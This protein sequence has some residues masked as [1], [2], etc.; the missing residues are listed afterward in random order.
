MDISTKYLGLELKNP[1]IVGS[2]GL[3][4][5]V[6]KIQKCEEAEAGAVV[7]K[8]LF[9]EQIR[10]MDSGVKGSV[11]MHPEV[12]DYIRSEIDMAYGPREYLKTIEQAKKSVSIPIIASINCYSS[13]WW[14]DYAQQ[15]ELAGADA[16]E[17]NIYT[18]PFDMTKSSTELEAIYLEILQRV[19]EQIKIPVSLK[20]SPYFTS[21]GHLAAKLAA[22]GANGLVLFN[23]FIQPE[24]N[25]DSIKI[26]LKGAFNDPVGFSYAS[27][28]I[29]LLSDT[30]NLD[31]A[32][33]GGIREASDVIKQILVGASAVQIASILYIDGLERIQSLLDGLRNW[34]AEKKF[35]SISEFKG[36]LNQEH[37]P[38]SQT[39][40]RVQ[41][42]KS[43][44]GVE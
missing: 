19:K 12:M 16:L 11:G 42:I 5:T 23:R 32:A 9:E 41:Y 13:K 40:I 22:Q 36:K 44:T 43:I 7:M 8:S 25:V 37:D 33:S 21:F 6:E 28:W 38:Q 20:L 1:I 14:T 10:E 29:A 26:A 4:K 35:S 30:L 31:I 24:I 34:M 2:C 15:M 27:R 3:T 17:L 18:L 39:Y